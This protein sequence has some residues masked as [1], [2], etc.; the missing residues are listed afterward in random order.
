MPTTLNRRRRNP[1][2]GADHRLVEEIGSV[3]LARRCE[4]IVLDLEGR[5]EL[6]AGLEDRAPRRCQPL[7]LDQDRRPAHPPLVSAVKPREKRTRGVQFCSAIKVPQLAF[8][9]R[10][11]G[12]MYSAA[13]NTEPCDTVV[14]E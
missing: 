12:G 9:V 6:D 4:V 11:V 10:E 1:C 14:A 8:T 2:R 7:R 13:K 5:S 3:V